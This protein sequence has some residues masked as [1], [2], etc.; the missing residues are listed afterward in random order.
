MNLLSPAGRT[1]RTAFLFALPHGGQRAA[2]TNAWSSMSA[3]AIRARARREAAT[4]FNGAFDRA[5]YRTAER[6]AVAA[7]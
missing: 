2:R 7:R 6:P 1:A 3:D 5:A 4:A